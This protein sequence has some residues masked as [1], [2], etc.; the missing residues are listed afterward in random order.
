[1]LVLFIPPVTIFCSIFIMLTRHRG[2]G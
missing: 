2:R 1:L